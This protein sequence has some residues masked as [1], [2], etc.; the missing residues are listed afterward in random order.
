MIKNKRK[1]GAETDSEST[2]GMNSMKRQTEVV[3]SS[4]CCGWFC[5]ADA[6][7]GPTLVLTQLPLSG[8]HGLHHPDGQG[9]LQHGYPHVCKADGACVEGRVLVSLC[10]YWVS[11]VNWKTNPMC[12]SSETH[13]HRIEAKQW[14]KR[15]VRSLTL[16]LY[17]TSPKPSS[18]YWRDPSS[19]F[20]LSPSTLQMKKKHSN[21]PVKMAAWGGQQPGN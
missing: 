5:R 12:P 9:G 20:G 10:S 21:S 3:T 14:A 8:T 18:L 16:V 7:M 17:K 13:S 19:S 4:P 1:P 11:V 6:Q 15:M 2:L